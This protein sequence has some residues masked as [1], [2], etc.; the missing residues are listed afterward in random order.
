MPASA[1][2]EYDTSSLPVTVAKDGFKFE[3]CVGR[4]PSCRDEK[5]KQSTKCLRLE[6]LPAI[7]LLCFS[8]VAQPRQDVPP[9]QELALE[10]NTSVGSLWEMP[11]FN[12]GG[13]EAFNFKRIASW[14]P[15]SNE[16][17]VASIVFQLTREGWMVIA[18]LSVRLENYKEVMVGTYR[19]SED[20]T[21]RTEELTKFGLEPLVLRVIRAKPRFEDS[22]PPIMPKLENK[23]NAI[24][25][26]GFYQA[27][28]ASDSFQL[29]L[30]NVS[31]K[32]VIA[33]DLFMPSADGNGGG[34]LRS[35]GGD[36]DHPL[37]L[38]GGISTHHIGVSRGGRMTRNGFVPD[39]ALQQTLIIRTVVFDDGT[40]EGLVE[41][42]AEM[43]AQRRGLDLQR[44]R[45]L[46]L[47]QRPGKPN[48]GEML[49]TLD[50]LKEEAY[51]LGKTADASVALELLALFPSLE[52][53]AKGSLVQ[54]VEGGLRDGKLE[55][56]RYI[57]DFEEMQ[58]QPGGHVTFAE[59][60][61][62][63]RATYEKLTTR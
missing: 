6:I 8:A 25:V 42:A 41:P 2:P 36:R 63:T 23:T 32:K 16:S 7:L 48:A 43:E 56:L 40:Y 55:L 3:H 49:T 62:Q 12:G 28:P 57:N 33:L 35:Q 30:R 38:P 27:A 46:L 5:M 17:P 13:G 14:E 15:S 21:L 54:S 22:L 10:V 29:T 26:V 39:A 61:K 60:I 1:D 45:I 20:E 44:R 19:L 47:L 9:K 51:A 24:E 58:K 52:E 59:W 50:E 53:Q 4:P 31:N 37:M 11:A 18:R 34:G